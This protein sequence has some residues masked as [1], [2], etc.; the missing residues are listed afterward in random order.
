METLFEF[1]EW[2][3]QAAFIPQAHSKVLRWLL[4]LP[5]W[6]HITFLL[7]WHL[8]N[9]EPW[10]ITAQDP[11][12]E[13]GQSLHGASCCHGSFAAQAKYFLM[14]RR[15]AEV[16]LSETMAI[17]GF[18]STKSRWGQPRPL[19]L[20]WVVACFNERVVYLISIYLPHFSPSFCCENFSGSLS[21]LITKR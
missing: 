11:L 7:L 19:C 4:L 2:L 17:H 5:P 13:P 10:A 21:C 14:I 3:W 20:S 15:T 16:T 12:S 1:S 6:S 8:D 18:L 9:M